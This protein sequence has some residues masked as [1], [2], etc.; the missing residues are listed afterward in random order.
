VLDKKELE[1]EKT[2]F[3]NLMKKMIRNEKEI[4]L[5]YLYKFMRN[6]FKFWKFR[7]I[8]HRVDK[9]VERKVKFVFI[10]LLKEDNK[11]IT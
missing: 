2:K 5:K 11:R 4:K 8:C 6:G 1:L 9:M 3:T 7:K 10:W